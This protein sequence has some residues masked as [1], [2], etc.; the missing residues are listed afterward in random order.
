[1]PYYPNGF[2]YE[3]NIY[4]LL[5]RLSK[6]LKR[7]IPLRNVPVKFWRDLKQ[8]GFNYIWLMGIWRRSPASRKVSLNDESLKDEYS[9]ILKDWTREDIPGSPYAVCAYEPD[10][11]FGTFDDLMALK[12]KINAL[13]LKLI[14]DFVPNHTALDH[15]WS[16]E[17][18]QRYICGDLNSVENYGREEFYKVDNKTFVAHG[19]D[20]N[21]PSWKDT[22]QLNYASQET[23]NVLINTLLQIAPYC[24]GLRCD[25][26][27]LVTNRI[28][29]Q[30]WSH[31][32]KNHTMP[33]EEFW[34]TAIN[35]IKA[36]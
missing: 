13:G 11:R 8:Q 3:I 12:K 1:M 2:I 4:I 6:E 15:P 5:N 34:V 35:A 17:Y 33:A 31:L 26:A 18:P 32:L 36:K 28:F 9:R 29:Q 16:K 21:F 24:D 14:L 7:K 30:T 19:K 25:M 10:E 23:R 22:I 27:M 20:P